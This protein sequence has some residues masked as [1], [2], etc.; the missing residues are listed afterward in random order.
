[1]ICAKPVMPIAVIR[2][3]SFQENFL[4]RSIKGIISNE[5]MNKPGHATPVVNLS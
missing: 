4:Y 3:R 1:M 5:K 2:G